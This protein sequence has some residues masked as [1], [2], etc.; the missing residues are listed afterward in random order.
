MARPSDQNNDLENATR[1]ELDRVLEALERTEARLHAMERQLAQA[2]RLA[3]LG[4]LVG[5][6]AHEFNNLLTPV[7][8]YAQLALSDPTDT[9]LARKALERAYKG[10]ERAARM[11]ATM[12]GFGRDSDEPQAC[13]VAESVAIAIETARMDALHEPLELQ[14]DVE[15]DLCAG[16]ACLSLQQVLVNLLLNARHAITPGPGTIRVVGACSTWNID[17]G[18]EDCCTI[19]VTDTGCG[20]DAHTLETL[21][22]PYQSGPTRNGKRGTGLGLSICKRLIESVGGS[23]DVQSEMG[24]GTTFTLHLPLGDAALLAREPAKTSAA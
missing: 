19:A 17:G 23:I 11:S 3:T 6:V 7:M 8:S 10:A 15:T 12:L 9:D 4:T 21:F 22:T 24:H 5:A 20:I 13:M 14:I 18:V 1:V 16:I 2:E